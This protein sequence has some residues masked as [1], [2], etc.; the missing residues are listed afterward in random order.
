MLSGLLISGEAE[1]NAV[2]VSFELSE[3]AVLTEVRG[4][5]L[6]VKTDRP[7]E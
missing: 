4:N 3:T 6:L 5:K 1:E 2:N 7:D